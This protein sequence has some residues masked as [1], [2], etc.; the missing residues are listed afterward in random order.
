MTRSPR[1]SETAPR[2]DATSE[3]ANHRHGDAA[4]A[5][6]NRHHT[7]WLGPAVH[8]HPPGAADTNARRVSEADAAV[9]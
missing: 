7:S 3:A 8:S 2:P 6:M 4:S 1:N 5:V 9:D